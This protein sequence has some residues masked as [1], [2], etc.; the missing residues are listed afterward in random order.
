MPSVSS[1]LSPSLEPVRLAALARVV[2]TL[3]AA[4]G[5]KMSPEEMVT[6]VAGV[7]TIAMIWTRNRVTPVAKSE[8]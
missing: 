5:I 1:I 4:F 7:E 3:I 6:L 8:N 2:L